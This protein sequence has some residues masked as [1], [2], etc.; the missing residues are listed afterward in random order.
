[1]PIFTQSGTGQYD[2]WLIDG[3]ENFSLLPANTIPG[4]VNDMPI[5]L[6][7][8]DGRF[9]STHI[10]ARHGKW[11]QRYQPDG[12]VATFIHKKLSSSGKIIQLVEDNKI[13]LALTLTPNASLILRNIGDFFSVTT[14]YYRSSP[15]EGDVIARYTGYQWAITPYIEKRR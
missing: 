1:M 10:T 15:L 7:V 5:R 2:Y 9:G 12:C 4:I 6:Q 13:G 11:M 3:G 14:I 8:G